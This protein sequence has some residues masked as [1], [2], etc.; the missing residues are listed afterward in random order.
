LFKIAKRFNKYAFENDMTPKDPTAKA[1][2]NATTEGIRLELPGNVEAE[3][4][5]N[6]DTT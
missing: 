6:L 1:S 2:N 4:E 3:D 5:L